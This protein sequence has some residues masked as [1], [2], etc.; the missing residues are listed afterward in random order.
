MTD[1]DKRIDTL[2]RLM[3][4]AK[5]LVIFTGAGISTESGVADFRGPDGIWT[6]QEKGLP[7]PPKTDWSQ[8][9]PN[10]AH[11]AIAQLQD[12]G[13]M[14]FLITQNVDN[15][16]LKS[17]IKSELI[18]EFHGNIMKLRCTSCANQFDSFPDLINVTCPICEKGK[19]V[20]SVVDFGDPIPPSVYEESVYHSRFCDCFV[21]AGSSL[22]VQPAATMPEIAYKSRA[23]LI[24]INREKTPLDDICHLRFWE[25]TGDVLPPTVTQIRKILA[26]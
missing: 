7:P 19:L 3:L 20:S 10:Q 6:R 16:H 17:G 21:V 23:K 25:S 22:V 15:L 2:A 5:H 12:M 13:I 11:L 4:E 8:I 1:F 18:A 14:K 26:I 9:E 24:I